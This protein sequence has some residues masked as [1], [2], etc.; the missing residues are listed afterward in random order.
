MILSPIHAPDRPA[1]M[2]GI[3]GAGAFPPPAAALWH[4]Y[5]T[6][7]GRVYYS[8]SVTKATQWTKPEEMMSPAE[9]R[10]P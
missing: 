3:A 8:N 1:K 7:D 5:R 6:P 2:N 10:V 9:V 4:E